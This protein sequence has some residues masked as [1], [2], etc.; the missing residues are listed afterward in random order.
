[1]LFYRRN[2]YTNPRIFWAYAI[3]PEQRF[4]VL[5]YTGSIQSR[6]KLHHDDNFVSYIF[7]A[8]CIPLVI[9]EL[10]QRSLSSLGNCCSSESMK[11]RSQ[12][13]SYMVWWQPYQCLHLCSA[14]LQ[15]PWLM[16]NAGFFCRSIF[17]VPL[18]SLDAYIIILMFIHHDPDVLLTSSY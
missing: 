14:L 8:W 11:A 12:T 2:D 18:H 5:Q 1:M 16:A 7:Y 4:R 6:R 10:Y 3:L 9:R 17:S 13:Q 15:P